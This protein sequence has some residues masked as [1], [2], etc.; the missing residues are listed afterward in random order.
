MV[1]L[2]LLLI[3]S[4]LFKSQSD[5]GE[6]WYNGRIV[7]QVNTRRQT[8][9]DICFGDCHDESHDVRPPLSATACLCECG[10]A[11][12]SIGC[13]LAQSWTRVTFL[14]PTRPDPHLGLDE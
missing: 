2:V 8:E 9:S 12:A 5:R 13:P 4:T 1:L 10:C 3:A 6:I 7:L 11:E 14:D